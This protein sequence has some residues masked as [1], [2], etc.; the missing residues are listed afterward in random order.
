ML[1]LHQLRQEYRLK[2]L[3][4][5]DLDRDPFKQF[6]K[7]FQEAVTAQI[8]E[9]NAMA[10]ATATTLGR[11][12]CR[13]VLLKEVL[14]EGFTFFTNTESRKGKELA[15][16][17]FACV[18]FYWHELERQII[19]SGKIEPLEKSHVEIYFAERPRESQLGAWASHQDQ[20]L[21]SREALEKAFRH[22][23]EKFA[24][25]PIPPPPYWGGY[26]LIP[27]RFEFWQGRTNRLHDRF[28]YQLQNAVWQLERLAP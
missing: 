7:W 4:I 2:A 3:D 5:N 24:N 6:T 28:R 13:M 15:D 17:P 9:M 18:T 11:P 23:E 1:N 20:I 21:P 12:S 27:D 10:L 26:L 14:D 8:P 16:N 19:I 25:S 22:Y